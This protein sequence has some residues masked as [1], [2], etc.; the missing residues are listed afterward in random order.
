MMKTGHAASFVIFGRQVEQLSSTSCPE[1]A[2]L[3]ESRHHY[4]QG[5]WTLVRAFLLS[6]IGDSCIS[7]KTILVEDREPKDAL[8][9]LLTRRP[10]LIEVRRTE[11]V[12]NNRLRQTLMVSSNPDS[13]RYNYNWSRVENERH[14]LEML[15]ACRRFHDEMFSTK[16]GMSITE[17]GRPNNVFYAS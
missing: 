14:R 2:E 13:T 12:R 16:I 6:L 7:P 4:H 1:T 10:G 15:R 3:L 17:F 11:G 8:N 9:D 5:E